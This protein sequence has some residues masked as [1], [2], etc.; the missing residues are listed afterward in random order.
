MVKKNTRDEGS[1]PFLDKTVLVT[2]SGR[3]IG[4]EIALHFAENGA[5]VIV[6]YFRNRRPAEE[7][8][9]LIRKQKRKAV[10]IK[11]NVGKVK[12]LE[13]L[14]NEIKK[15]FKGLD[16][17]I[18]NAASGYNR[19]LLEQ[20][21]KGWDWTLD[22][23]TKAFLFATQLAVPLMELRGGGHIVCISS[24]GAR[25]VANDYSV[26][27]ASKAAL[28]TLAKYCAVELADK[29][30]IVNSVAPGLVKTEAL[31]HF[32]FKD[33]HMETPAG[34][35]VNPED[36]AKVVAFLCSPSAFMIRGQVLQVDG[37]H[38]LLP[39]YFKIHR[40]L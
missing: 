14:F 40:T 22:I 37:G 23:N 33:L 39:S 21:E 31:E 34:R 35:M 5:N 30:I 19:P 15:E 8:A 24:P 16:I 10:L 17:F 3:G 29:N 9:N 32:D 20:R 12:E 11:A 7:T 26:V 1:I 2:G 38:S 13:L 6:N 28:E 18:S 25:R 4:R 36:V 27:G